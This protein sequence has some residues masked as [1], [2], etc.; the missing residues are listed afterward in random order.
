MART[1][2]F[3]NYCAAAQPPNNKGM[4]HRAVSHTVRLFLLTLAAGLAAFCL[5]AAAA[6]DSLQGPHR[7]LRHWPGYYRAMAEREPQNEETWLTGLL[8]IE[9]A[10]TDALVRLAAI[11][12]WRGDLVRARTLL[13]R[14]AG[15]DARY[16][17]QWALLEF[18]SRHANRGGPGIWKVARRCFTMSY[19]D[20]QALL[21][22]VWGLNPHGASLLETVIPDLPPVLFYTTSFLMEQGDLA[23]ARQA[24]SRLIAQP[25]GSASRAN[26]GIVGTAEER[27]HLGLDLADLHLDRHDPDSAIG[28]WHSLERRHLVA[29]DGGGEAGVQVVNPRFHTA[30]LGRGF[31]WRVTS[32]PGVEMRRT[33]GG[34]RVDFAARPPDRAVLLTQRVILKP[35]QI[36]RPEVIASAPSWVRASLSDEATGREIVE[37]SPRTRVARLRIE[38]CRPSGQ[39]PLREPLV[40]RQVRWGRA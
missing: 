25:L 22:T 10:D 15:H 5:T 19:G 23:A 12:E 31:D 29:V 7:L 8:A 21:E 11:F 39:P 40:I 20:R 3:A 33:E 36:P 2:Q 6:I 24:F 30:P 14:A 37:S 28:I 17:A 13:V 27:A 18:E 26:A 35:G 1:R 4:R 34:W 9:P 32:S 38:Y 16:R